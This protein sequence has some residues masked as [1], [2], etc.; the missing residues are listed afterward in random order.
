[1]NESYDKLFSKK[2]HQYEPFV[3]GLKLQILFYPSS[4]IRFSFSLTNN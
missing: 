1:M 2:L 4:N 3:V